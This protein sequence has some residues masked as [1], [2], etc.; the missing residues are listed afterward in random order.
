VHP[1]ETA[2]AVARDLDAEFRQVPPRYDRPEV[3][4]AQ[5]RRLVQEVVAGTGA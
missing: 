2:I 1:V 5:V 4:A 3:H